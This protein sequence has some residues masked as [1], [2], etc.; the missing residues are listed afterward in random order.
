MGGAMKNRGYWLRLAGLCVVTWSA[1]A[2]ASAQSGNYP[3]NTV[4]IISDAAAGA[5]P[6]VATRFL[7]EGLGKIWGQQVVVVNHPGANGSVAARI[8]TDAVAD[9]YTLFMPAASTFVALPTVAPNLP[10]RLPRD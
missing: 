1:A 10:L 8:A 9:G 6:D 5:S 7:A 4:T 3:N 2:G